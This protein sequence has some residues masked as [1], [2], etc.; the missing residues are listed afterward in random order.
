[1]LTLSSRMLPALDR[2]VGSLNHRC[3][4]SH[5]LAEPHHSRRMADYNDS[6]LLAHPNDQPYLPRLSGAGSLR[7]ELEAVLDVAPVQTSLDAYRKLIME[8][9]AARKR[10]A[11][12]RRWTW[13]RLKVRYLLDR[14]I[15]EFRAFECAIRSTIDP[16]ERGLLALLLMARSDRLFR[17]VITDQVSPNLRRPGT[18]INELEMH[19]AVERIAKRT[20]AHWSPSVLDGLTSHMLS[21]AKD[22]G[23]LQGSRM[24]RTVEINPGPISVSFAIRL[25]RLEGLSDRRTLESRWFRLLGL[26]LGNVL[27]L[28]HR[29]ARQGALRFRFQADLAEI[30]L[31]ELQEA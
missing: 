11:S 20:N 2:L 24:K 12:M 7:K 9:N 31:P 8:G 16:A 22:Y 29:T 30:V 19:S 25:S 1:M 23:L 4:P 5:A 13:W 28:M 27:D 15:D 26:E 17:E 3:A 14:R 21:S 6:A 10:S 18:L